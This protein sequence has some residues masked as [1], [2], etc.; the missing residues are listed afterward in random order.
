MTPMIQIQYQNQ[1]QLQIQTLNWPQSQSHSHPVAWM[2]LEVKFEG[3]VLCGTLVCN[4]HSPIHK[5]DLYRTIGEGYL[6]RS[7]WRSKSWHV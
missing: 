1:I 3:Q 6:L 2:G 5:H 7:G 4:S